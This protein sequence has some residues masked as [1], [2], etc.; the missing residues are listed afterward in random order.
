MGIVVGATSGKFVMVAA[1]LLFQ[2]RVDGDP[3]PAAIAPAAPVSTLGARLAQR[4]HAH[5]RPGARVKIGIRGD[6]FYASVDAIDHDPSPAADLVIGQ[7]I[8]AAHPIAIDFRRHEL[9][10]LL[11]G[12]VRARQRHDRAIMLRPDGAGHWRVALAMPDGSDIDA[13]L[14]L[15]SAAAIQLGTDARDAMPADGVTV[16]LG[17]VTLAGVTVRRTGGDTTTVGLGAFAG[18][19]IILDLAHDRIWVETGRDAS[20]K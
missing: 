1:L 10:T 19:R 13:M 15:G 4:L 2:V 8:L 9:A 18:Q 20:G 17:G 6:Y 3:V 14:D 12:Q 7:D 5:G 16:T 11:P